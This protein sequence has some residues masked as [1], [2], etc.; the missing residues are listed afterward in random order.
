MPARLFLL[1]GQFEIE[2]THVQ[3]KN[4][5]V[6][7]DDRPEHKGDGINEPDDGAHQDNED[8]GQAKIIHTSGLPNLVYLRYESNRCEK[9]ADMSKYFYPIHDAVVSTVN[10]GTC[11]INVAGL[12]Y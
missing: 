12:F 11:L 3:D 4:D 1:V 9:C 8:H 5:T 10:T 6:R 2:K 7:D